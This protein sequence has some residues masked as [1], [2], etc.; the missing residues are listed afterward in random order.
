VSIT[1]RHVLSWVGSLLKP[2]PVRRIFWPQKS[3]S[4]YAEREKYY[5]ALNGIE[6]ESSEV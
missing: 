6:P 5:G 1:D 3:K 2:L 4:C